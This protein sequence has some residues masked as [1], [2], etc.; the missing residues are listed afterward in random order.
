MKKIKYLILIVGIFTLSGCSI[1]YNMEIYNDKIKENVSISETNLD[2]LKDTEKR[3]LLE[4]SLT[5]TYDYWKATNNTNYKLDKIIKDKE[6]TLKITGKHKLEVSPSLVTVTNCYKNFN[7]VETDNSYILSTSKEN[8]CFEAN[9]NL[10]EINIKI[11]TNHRVIN[12]NAHTRK[13]DTYIWKLNKDNYNDAPIQLEF[14]KDKY[15]INYNNKLFK[16]MGLIIL[17]IGVTLIII[18][19]IYKK[20]N[21]DVN[22]R[23]DVKR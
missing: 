8:I 4:E 6:L 10:D 18:L 2:I 19:P 7:I 22:F 14:Y 5:V 11:S 3:N 1:D 21:D 17:V 20:R 13:K 16:I 23:M 9:E 12:H 15:V